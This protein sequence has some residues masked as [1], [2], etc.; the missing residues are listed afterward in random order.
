M[1]RTRTESRQF[2]S[3]TGT[4][5]EYVEIVDPV[6]GLQYVLDSAHEIAY[7]IHVKVSVHASAAPQPCLAGKPMA[8]SLAG[9][10]ATLNEGLG[11]KIIDGLAVCGR[12]TT[13]TYPAG[14]AIF[15]NDR[16]VSTVSEDWASWEELGRL[17]STSHTQPGI[18]VMIGSLKNL[19]LEEPD[20]SLFR[21]P[22]NY[23][24]VDESA[25]F[26]VPLET[27]KPSRQQPRSVTALTGMPYSAEQVLSMDEVLGDGTKLT[28]ESSL[29]RHFR[30]L[31]GRTR[32]DR[33]SMGVEIVDP[34]AGYSYRLDPVN[35]IAVRTPIEVKFGLA[36]AA[37]APPA[38]AGQPAREWLGEQT[39]DGMTTYGIRHTTT[40]PA[41][42]A[43]ADRPTKMVDER[44]RSPQLG[45]DMVSRISNPRASDFTMTVRNLTFAE[46]DAALF[47]I[48]DGYRVVD[49]PAF[50]SR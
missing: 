8:G 43:G 49:D 16:P 23:R 10:I 15:G 45:I 2:L 18:G 5:F 31:A 28:H 4:F 32:V 1:G 33:G 9:N 14:S 3:E 46:P 11:S 24:I 12:R 41:G 19:R 21:P 17:V 30:D 20:P 27:A 48:P 6:D 13:L 7:R 47:R 44:W 40:F 25:E 22:A 34:V 50:A 29:A 37:S 26:T 42:S 36:Q 35:E 38:G 39:V